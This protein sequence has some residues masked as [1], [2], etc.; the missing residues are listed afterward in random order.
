MVSPA[1]KKI[2]IHYLLSLTIIGV[3]FSILYIVFPP[4]RIH[5]I[6]SNELLDI[7]TATFFAITF[8]IGLYYSRFIH[9]QRYRNIYLVITLMSFV[10]FFSEV[11][12]GFHHIVQHELYDLGI[13]SWT[14]IIVI[15]SVVVGV[16][17]MLVLRYLHHL[18]NFTSWLRYNIPIV[19]FLVAFSL[20]FLGSIG[21]DKFNV[22]GIRSITFVEELCELNMAVSLLFCVIYLR[23]TVSSIL[24]TTLTAAVNP[25]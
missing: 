24:D 7:T 5:I 16:T 22:R 15:V 23:S 2:L 9:T 12:L 11:R 17:L 8:V 21:L 6:A 10:G 18:P 4:L 3:I 1:Q 20:F 19:I 25:S 13:T 14:Q